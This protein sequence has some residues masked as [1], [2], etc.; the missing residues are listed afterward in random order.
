MFKVSLEVIQCIYDL[1]QLCILKTASRRVKQTKI[2]ASAVSIYIMQG[3]F[4]SYVF[5]FWGHSE[6]H[7]WFSPTLYLKNGWS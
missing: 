3:T 1:C 6:V 5:T 7:F 4:D 2:G